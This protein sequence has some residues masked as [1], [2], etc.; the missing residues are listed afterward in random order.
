MSNRL[1]VCGSVSKTKHVCKTV[2]NV[3][4]CSIL[5]IATWQTILIDLAKNVEFAVS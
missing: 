5:A 1:R 3:R 4:I 2:T